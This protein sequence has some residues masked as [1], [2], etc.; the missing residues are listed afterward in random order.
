ARGARWRAPPRHL[1][2]LLLSAEPIQPL[3]PTPQLGDL[4]C[5][6]LEEG[7][8]PPLVLLHGLGSSAR[9][10]EFQFHVYS[11]S[12][13]VIAPDLRGFGASERKGPFRIE[14]FAQDVWALLT[15]L[16]IDTFRLVG[17]SMGGAVALEM[18]T[19]QP[20]RI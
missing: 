1:G 14:Q 12:F 8:G 4:R 5:H 17:Y 18:A 3:M 6:Y 19:S 2:A 20:W 7:S 15:Q 13:R 10:W 11:R 9:D 16:G